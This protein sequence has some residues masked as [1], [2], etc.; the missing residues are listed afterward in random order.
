MTSEVW[1]PL[2][3]RLAGGGGLREGVPAVLRQP[4]RDWI[5]SQAYRQDSVVERIQVRLGLARSVGG[6]DETAPHH[7]LAYETS[8]RRLLDIVDALLSFPPRG[9]IASGVLARSL[10]LSRKRSLQELLDDAR[11]VYT[12]SA[13]GRGLERRA[14]A[15]ATEASVMAAQMAEGK[16]DAGSAAGHLRA[17]WATAYALEPDPVRAYSEA[18]KAVEAAAHAVADPGNPK[19]TLGSMIRA[20]RDRPR[21]F[22]VALG[23]Q[24]ASAL[25]SV[26]AMMALLWEGQTSRHGGKAPTRPETAEEA[27]MAVLLAVTLVEWFVSGAVRRI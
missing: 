25:E 24:S 22:S 16:P 12:V 17:A 18:V 2:S 26:A 10:I 7:W 8:D 11:S 19:A 9:V 3:V 21:A 15:V 5:Q 27:R 23:G 4:L 14:G 13:D 6:E 1:Q 20:V